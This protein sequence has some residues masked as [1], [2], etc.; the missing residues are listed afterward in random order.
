MAEKGYRTYEIELK[1]QGYCGS[2]R[3]K[4]KVPKGLKVFDIKCLLF[5][6][7]ALFGDI[8][9]N[10]L[11]RS[12]ATKEEKDLAIEVYRYMGAGHEAIT[13][14]MKELT[15]WEIKPVKAVDIYFEYKI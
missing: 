8:K 15:G 13:G 1:E 12:S 4:V 2:Y 14:Y 10:R 11:L 5:K 6:A 7:V 3:Y 9:E